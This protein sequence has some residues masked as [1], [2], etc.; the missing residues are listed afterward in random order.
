[1]AIYARR[2]NAVA[3]ER[4]IKESELNTEIAV[5]EKK[6]QIRQTQMQADIAVEEQRK[7]LVDVRAENE[8]KDADTR[9][10]AA[11]MLFKAVAGVD[12]KTLLALSGGGADPRLLI[13]NAFDELAKNAQKIGTLNVTPELLQTLVR[14][15]EP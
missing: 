12:W 8:R 6:R 4:K 1:M 5:E 11:E 2:N 7:T 3:E 10:Y 13:A 15:Q 9:A 14:K